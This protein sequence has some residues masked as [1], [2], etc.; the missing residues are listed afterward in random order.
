MM[1]VTDLMCSGFFQLDHAVYP[2]FQPGNSYTIQREVDGRVYEWR[3]L[4][5]LIDV[6]VVTFVC[7]PVRPVSL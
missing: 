2:M 3:G 7:P 5:P 1:K 4:V 6:G